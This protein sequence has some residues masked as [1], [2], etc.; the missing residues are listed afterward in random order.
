MPPCLP[1]VLSILTLE[2]T[3]NSMLSSLLAAAATT[4][5]QWS[6][7]GKQ[8]KRIPLVNCTQMKR[9]SRNAC[10]AVQNSASVHSVCTAVELKPTR[11]NAPEEQEEEPV[12]MAWLTACMFQLDLRP[13][14]QIRILKKKKNII[15]A[16]VIVAR[17]WRCWPLAS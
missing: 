16:S 14:S 5:A 9:P 3:Y 2:L 17:S 13:C 12:N 4:A 11:S 15:Q 10:A 8:A 1:R 6:Q 7:G